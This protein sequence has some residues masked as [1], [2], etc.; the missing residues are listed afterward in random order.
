MNKRYFC[1]FSLLL[2]LLLGCASPQPSKQTL[3][4][5]LRSI[6]PEAS[7][8]EVQRLDRQIKQSA[9]RLFNIYDRQ[10]HP[11]LHNLLVNLGIKQKGLC[12]HFADA[13]YLDLL[14]GKQR[15][16]SF[17]FHLIVSNKGSFWEHNAVL[18]TSC[19]KEIERGVV[20]DLWRNRG[21][22]THYLL[23]KDPE[24]RWRHRDDRCL[25][26]KKE[27]RFYR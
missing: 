1:F 8:F 15:Y 21:R 24:Y 12:W 3:K 14:K 18:V 20:I 16:P 11:L 27:G 26:A 17:C 10:T 22:I 13:L 4:R 23:K 9:G 5:Q 7:C 2:L 6:N 25:C 19:H